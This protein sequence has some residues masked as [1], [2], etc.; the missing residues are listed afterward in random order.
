MPPENSWE[1]VLPKESAVGPDKTPES[2]NVST[3]LVTK[4][5]NSAEGNTVNSSAQT[6]DEG[7][8]GCAWTI[9]ALVVGVLL[10][11]GTCKMGRF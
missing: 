10:L 4:E 5:N 3:D 9:I 2:E 7:L 8:G 11:L 6:P 1:I